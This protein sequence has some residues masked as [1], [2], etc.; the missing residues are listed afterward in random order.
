VRRYGV[1]LS[2]QPFGVQPGRGRFPVR[3]RIIAALAD[4]VVVV[5]A[6]TA[7]PQ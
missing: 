2:E 5:E 7:E 6:T 3:N 1:L 4:V